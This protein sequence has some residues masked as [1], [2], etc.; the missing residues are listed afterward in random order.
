MQHISDWLGN[1]GL[2]EY[3]Q[4]F[5]DN[6][7]DVSVLR[8]L[9][10]QDLKEIGI[11][12]GHR[13]KILA[14]ISELTGVSATTHKFGDVMGPVTR[15]AERRQVTVMFLDLVDSVAL[16]GRMDPEDLREVISAYQN[17]AAEIVGHF[18]GFV[19][20]YM[21]DGVLVFFG[22]P[23]AQEDDAERAVWA[24]LEL[25]A[26]V[27]GLKTLA[28]LQARVGIAT[29][30]VVVGDLIG[31]GDAREHSIVGDTPN[32]AARLQGIAEPNTVVI[33]DVTRRILG[34]LFEVK[35]LGF[36]D[37][38][39]FPRPMR[40][41]AA[42]RANAVAS[43]FEALRAASL[44]ALVGRDEEL[45]LLLRRWQKAKSGEGQV[46][47][48]CGEAGIGKSRLAFALQQSIA[49][50][51]HVRLRYFSS[52]QHTDSVFYPIIGQMERAAG[53]VH[54]DTL[55]EKLDKLDTILV[56]TSTSNV[57]SALLAEML[58]L[59]N[60]GRYAVLD[61]TPEQRRQRTM[62]ALVSRLQAL[63]RSGPVL[64]ISE[65][66][67]WTDPTSLEVLDRVV[68]SSATLRALLIV[69]YRPE[70]DPPWIGQP[71]VTALTLNRLPQREA[72]V[73]IDNLVGS[74]VL[75]TSIRLDLIERSDGIPLFVEEMTKAVLEAGSQNAAERTVAAIPSQGLAVPAT[76]HASLMARLDRLGVAKEVAQIGAAIGR[77][78]SHALLAGVARKSEAEL[79]EA[80]DALIVAGLLFRHGAPPRASYLFKHSLVQDAAYGMQL[81]EPRRVLHARI[82]ETLETQFAEMAER[83]P[84]LLA[85]HCTEAGLVEKAATLW[86][87]AGQRA[88]ERS[89][90]VE[91][92]EHLTRALAQIAALP[93][94]AAL[95]RKEI[96]LQVAL[97]TPLMHV[98]GYAAP[99]TKTA[100]ERARL[101]IEE[102]EA[103][104]EHPDDPLLL[105]SVLFS[106]WTASFVAF[107]GDALRERANQFLTLAERRGAMAPIMIGHRIMGSVL[108]TGAFVEGRA[109]L[110]R[111]IT[112]YDPVEHRP[113]ATRFGQDVR[114]AALSYRSW[115]LWMLGHPDAGLADASDA[116]EE[117]HEIGQAATLMYALVHALL[118]HMLCGNFAAAKADADELVALGNEK[119]A[120]FWTAQGM[121]MHGCILAATGKAA[122]AV[123]MISSGITAW[124]STGSTFWMPLYLSYL[125][126]AHAEL[127]QF[128]SAWRCID[129]AMT[130][131]E[132]RKERWHQAEIYRLAGEIAVESPTPDLVK[133]V[134]YFQRA[135]AIARAQ[136]AKSW[137]LRAAMSLARL[138]R[139]QGKGQ[140]G[141]DQLASVLGWFTE[142]F[143]TLD[144]R[145]GSALLEL[146]STEEGRHGKS[147]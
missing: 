8:Y 138:W 34:N 68:Q 99:E 129:E 101:L 15:D 143:D 121:S 66:A 118:I 124:R 110:D 92:T 47:L 25:I 100:A 77:E 53:L 69:T 11:P 128:E 35:D 140:Q 17:C 83:Q 116:L 1:L 60:D 145:E 63:A 37:L 31:S 81:R 18:G 144:L 27:A 120:L 84:E 2:S 75:P 56:Q 108:H 44:I 133:A 12:L 147:V 58:S 131:A 59:Q 86:G 123:Q 141:R 16:S 64:I 96:Q 36:R 51:T 45:G 7:I 122:D 23:R 46:V 62:D 114:V 111:A 3:I 88:L 109:H 104:G 57:D 95:R 28:S 117:A 67:H 70:F 113:L 49:T 61:Y 90:L 142:G 10:D 55:Q 135:L 38:K 78:F 74:Q 26:A 33:C 52:P 22:Y 102:A 97:I 43:R 41:W 14:A 85:H 54:G 93:L 73:M 146:L 32:L 79:R 39:G 40:S 24:G 19:A 130:A 132:T 9:T 20:R 4:C 136:Q 139:R 29:G 6:K 65:D 30:L 48:L 137:E 134:D 42:L 21:G 80:L 119:N 91:A 82:A 98:K 127:G 126:S 50:E 72:G 94:T 105:F 87:K 125:A 89:A 71:H 76:L 107:D 103:R 112:L 106:F 115:A 5:V 13:R